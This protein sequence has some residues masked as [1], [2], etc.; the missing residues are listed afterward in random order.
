MNDDHSPEVLVVRLD[1]GSLGE[2]AHRVADL[3]NEQLDT[4]APAPPPVDNDGRL[5]SAAQV[6]TRW[7]VDRS[8]VYDHADDLGVRRLGTG[9]RPRLRFDAAAVAAYL[10]DAEATPAVGARRAEAAADVRRSPGMGSD[11]GE[12]LPIRGRP[13]LSSVTQR[14]RRPGGAATPP[15]TAPKRRASAR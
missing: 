10:E 13:E 9:V 12:G 5:L 11:C 3:V 1:P 15:A 14:S 6:A 7:G 8:W 4:T 2:L